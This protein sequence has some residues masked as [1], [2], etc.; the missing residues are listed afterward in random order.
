MEMGENITEDIYG[1]KTDVTNKSK[2]FSHVALTNNNII[3]VTIRKE[4]AAPSLDIKEGLGDVFGNNEDT[5][6]IMNE[7]HIAFITTYHV[8][9]KKFSISIYLD[10]F[11]SNH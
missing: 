5:F 11:Q 9:V 4:V 7:E 8:L 6:R 10:V 1:D 2:Q 3:Q